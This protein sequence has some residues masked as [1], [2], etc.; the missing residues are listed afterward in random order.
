MTAYRKALAA[1]LTAVST[2]GGTALLD[3]GI[4]GAEWFGLL[5]VL[6]A[7]LVYATPNR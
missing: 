2:W 7:A 1:L 4:T 5:G 6:G 3:D